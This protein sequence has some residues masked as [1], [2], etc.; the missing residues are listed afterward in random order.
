VELKLKDLSPGEVETIRDTLGVRPTSS[1]RY[2]LTAA[3]TWLRRTYA[4][5]ARQNYG[6]DSEAA[7][8]W[9]KRDTALFN[10]PGV[11]W[12]RHDAKRFEQDSIVVEGLFLKFGL[13]TAWE[14][15]DN[16][17]W[18]EVDKHVG[19]MVCQAL[20]LVGLPYEWEFQDP[21]RCIHVFS[22]RSE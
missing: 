4:F 20:A 15:E 13:I 21:A 19:T 7:I 14:R 5:V 1:D 22:S 16:T 9:L 11:F 12:T 8:A 6:T 2:R 10:R 18:R 17:N 3:F